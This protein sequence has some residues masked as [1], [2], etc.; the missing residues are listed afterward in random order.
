[1]P[2]RVELDDCLTEEW[3][4]QNVDVVAGADGI[5]TKRAQNIPGRHL[6]DVIVAANAVHFRVVRLLENAA[7]P[8][9]RKPRLARLH[10]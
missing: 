7:D 4:A 9:L 8:F 10:E 3:T 2:F 1:M 5:E 6:S